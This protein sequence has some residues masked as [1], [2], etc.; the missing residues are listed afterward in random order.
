MK[1]KLEHNKTLGAYGVIPLEGVMQGT[2]VATV[3]AIVLDNVQS[4]GGCVRGDVVAV[5]GAVLA[6]DIDNDT[7]LGLMV[8]QVW[9]E[10][11]SA[12]LREFYAVDE[13]E[14]TT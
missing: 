11:G 14:V 8:G 7:V 3:E 13:M 6:P 10:S 12:G 4:D 9:P 1:I 5:W 2:S